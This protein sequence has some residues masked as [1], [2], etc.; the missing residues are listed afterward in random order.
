MHPRI[1][2]D[3]SVI[4]G[5]FDSEFEAASQ[6]LFRHFSAGKAT[7]V[8][9]DITLLEL[10]PAPER[11]RQLVDAL[12]SEYVEEVRLTS[13]AEELADSYISSGVIGASSRA[14]AEHIATATI[15][16]VTVL[17][18]WNLKHIVNLE[19]IHGYNSVNL[20]LG[21]PMIEIRTPIEVI[22]HES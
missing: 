18:S 22:E 2:T 5:Y 14:D 12:P 8:I 17:V 7:L 10:A 6:A 15:H 16:R 1:Y 21:Y 19:R 13:E 20:R 3:T 4:G 9:S 11:I